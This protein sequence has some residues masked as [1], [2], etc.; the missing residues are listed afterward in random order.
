MD[1]RER[2]LREE[3]EQYSNNFNEYSKNLT[4]VQKGFVL[5]SVL[6]Y[7]YTKGIQDLPVEKEEENFTVNDS[8]IVSI[9]EPDELT[10][11]QRPNL[12]YDDIKIVVSKKGLFSNPTRIL[13]E[14]A[15][16]KSNGFEFALD[17]NGNKDI[18]HLV[19]KS[20]GNE[21]RLKSER[22]QTSIEGR[23]VNSKLTKSLGYPIPSNAV[24]S[25]ILT[26]V[27]SNKG[28]EA[29]SVKHPV[30]NFTK[31]QIET[32]LELP[33]TI[34]A[35]ADQ[36]INISEKHMLSFQDAG[37]SWIEKN[38]PHSTD[39]RV[40]GFINDYIKQMT[41]EM[42]KMTAY[43]QEHS[44]EDGEHVSI[45]LSEFVSM[46]D[47]QKQI[48]RVA[49]EIGRETGEKPEIIKTGKDSFEFIVPLKVN[50][51]MFEYKLDISPEMGNNKN[52]FVVAGLQISNPALEKMGR[53]ITK[54][55]IVEAA[56]ERARQT[57]V[58]F[59]DIAY[60][61]NEGN[62]D[63]IFD[64]RFCNATFSLSNISADE[65]GKT[66][67]GIINGTTPVYAHSTARA[68]LQENGGYQLDIK[69]TTAQ[70]AVRLEQSSKDL[71]DELVNT[72]KALEY[73]PIDK[74][75]KHYE[76]N[77][78]VFGD[79]SVELIADNSDGSFTVS[80]MIDD[81]PIEIFA[82]D[83]ELAVR[84]AL[85]NILNGDR[86]LDL[87]RTTEDIQKTLGAK[88]GIVSYEQLGKALVSEYEKAHAPA[89]QI[90]G[91]IN[92]ENAI[93]MN[94]GMDSSKL[95][96]VEPIYAVERFFKSEQ[97]VIDYAS[98]QVGGQSILDSMVHL[99]NGLFVETYNLS[100]ELAREIRQTKDVP[101]V[102]VRITDNSQETII[103]YKTEEPSVQNPD[104]KVPVVGP[105][106]VEFKDVED[107]SLQKDTLVLIL[108]RTESGNPRNIEMTKRVVGNVEKTFDKDTAKALGLGATFGK[109]AERNNEARD[110]MNNI[111][112]KTR[113]INEMLRD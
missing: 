63:V 41:D 5:E 66:L 36:I 46:S 24:T 68:V 40:S 62:A 17:E 12:G 90:I 112:N 111:L 52:K 19:D 51:Q 39:E 97:E 9:D 84:K 103:G 77:G 22:G 82:V 23:I 48:N 101:A 31:E 32:V 100:E 57:D 4:S 59:N 109:E 60:S 74:T 89:E 113:E 13:K 45:S 54:K 95:I 20:S 78:I 42:V 65:L 64:D 35:I 75:F 8:R 91:L 10:V 16:D 83:N 85:T 102:G 56:K 94:T 26:D 92:D 15:G 7:T 70:E 49:S 110:A 107:Y 79:L 88:D 73:T 67:K 28:F 25:E 108:S 71:I 1:A 33:E 86:H 58:E 38:K 53:D 81:V 11:P 14:L 72:A 47:V 44:I 18:T 27:I 37:F 69:K 104:G 80:V 76:A 6:K 96:E 29:K 55:H 61:M 34:N 87:S 21:I 3:L 98:T 30:C 99:N 2:V 93:R 43:Q 105:M 106:M 50:G